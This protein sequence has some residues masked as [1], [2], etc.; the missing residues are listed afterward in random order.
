MGRFKAEAVILRDLDDL[1]ILFKDRETIYIFPKESSTNIIFHRWF[2][3]KGSYT[4]GWQDFRRALW[5][6]AKLDVPTIYRLGIKYG[7]Q[8]MG[9]HRAP[10]IEGKKLKIIYE[11]R[12]KC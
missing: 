2:A 3:P 8:T 11:R 4:A 7:I 5:R 10:N 9:T 12:R 6:N 1:T